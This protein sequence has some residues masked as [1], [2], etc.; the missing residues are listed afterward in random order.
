MTAKMK[1]NKVKNA[2]APDGKKCSLFNIS[3]FDTPTQPSKYS[4]GAL[5]RVRGIQQIVLI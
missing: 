1:I 2:R 5:T 4:V 3:F